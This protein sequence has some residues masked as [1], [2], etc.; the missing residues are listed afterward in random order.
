[1]YP[2]LLL[3]TNRQPDA[4]S[5]GWDHT[6]AS[7]FDYERRR[8]RCLYGPNDR[9]RDSNVR[10]A[11]PTDAAGRHNRGVREPNVPLVTSGRRWPRLHLREQAD[12]D[13]IR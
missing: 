10:R 13:G 12:I 9:A 11:R 8:D 4:V 6:D 1:M 5:A 3:E 2:Y 7:H